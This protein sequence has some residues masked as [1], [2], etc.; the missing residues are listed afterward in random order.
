MRGVVVGQGS[1]VTLMHIALMYRANLSPS[2]NITETVATGWQMIKCLP[3]Y[4]GGQSLVTRSHIYTCFSCKTEHY[5]SVFVFVL[6]R[7]KCTLTNEC[8]YT[9]VC[10]FIQYVAVEHFFGIS[11]LSQGRSNILATRT[12]AMTTIYHKCN[13]KVIWDVLQPRLFLHRQHH[14]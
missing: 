12:Q 1:H 2:E 10:R 8:R 13:K 6:P 14:I 5:R 9:R 3:W 7:H 11:S 4:L